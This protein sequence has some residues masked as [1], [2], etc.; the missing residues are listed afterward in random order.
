MG[1]GARFSPHTPLDGLESELLFHVHDGKRQAWYERDLAVLS[2]DIASGKIEG[3]SGESGSHLEAAEA[4]ACRGRFTDLENSA[5]NSAPCPGR[6]YEKSSYL[7]CFVARIEER[8]LT[9]GAM[10]TSIERLALA[11]ASASGYD[12]FLAHL[13]FCNEIGAVLNQLGIHA[14]YA[15][16]SQLELLRRIVFRLQTQDGRAYELLQS[17]DIAGKSLADREVHG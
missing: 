16:E 12:F 2:F 4:H 14:K 7:R 9:T 17:G 11:P 8:I 15:V 1:L 6:V 13:D 3:H 5:A 10:V